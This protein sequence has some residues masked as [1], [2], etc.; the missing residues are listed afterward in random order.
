MLHLNV[1]MVEPQSAE[2]L[3]LHVGFSAEEEFL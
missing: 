1:A 2:A 3:K